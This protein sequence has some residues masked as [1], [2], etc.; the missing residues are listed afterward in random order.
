[1][2][3]KSF[4]SNKLSTDEFQAELL[5]VVRSDMKDLVHTNPNVTIMQQDFKEK[6]LPYV[7][8]QVL[9]RFKQDLPK[10]KSEGENFADELQEYL[11]NDVKDRLIK[12][13]SESL[14][15]VE[16]V[17]KEEYPQMSADELQRILDEARHVFVIRIT[18]IIEKKITYISDDL[19]SLKASIDNFKNCKEYTMHD[20]SNPHTVHAV[21]VEMV[22][23]MLELV[24]YQLNEEKGQLPVE[25]LKGGAK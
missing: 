25:P 17:L 8:K 12:A 24:I 6:V 7:A 2:N 4:V 18:D 20:A 15:E 23:A 10:F 22:E 21:K 19:N 11:E 3:L 5:A 1:M 14:V 9:A 13:L 16:G